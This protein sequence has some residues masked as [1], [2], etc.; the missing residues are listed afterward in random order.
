MIPMV[1]DGGI[2]AL[3]SYESTNG[4]RFITGLLFGCGL[5]S[6]FFTSTAFAFRWGVQLGMGLSIT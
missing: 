6:L 1:L 4:R 3:S 2:Q 5:M